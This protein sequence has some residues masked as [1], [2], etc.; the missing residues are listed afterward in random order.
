MALNLVGLPVEYFPNP[1]KARPVFNG[2]I[3]VG[4][5]G[6]DPQEPANQKQV[7]V[8]DTGIT[9][10][11]VA[12]AQPIS[13]GNAGVPVWP[14]S[15]QNPVSVFVDGA[16]SIKV[17]DNND[18]QVYYFEDVTD[19]APLTP[20]TG[21]S[22]VDTIADL[23]SFEPTLDGQQ[24]S[25]KQH[26]TGGIGGGIFIWDSS[27]LTTEVSNDVESAVYVAPSIDLTGASGSW[28]RSERDTLKL[29]MFG[30]IPD[31][32]RTTRIGTDNQ[33]KLNA[34][35]VLCF[36][37]GSKLII[38]GDYGV[39]SE[40]LAQPITRNGLGSG[41][42]GLFAIADNHRIYTWSPS[43]T[44]GVSIMKDFTIQGYA[45]DNTTQGS[46]AN[47]LVEISPMDEAYFIGMTGA[48]GREM[49]FKSRATISIADNCYMHHILRD[50]INFTDAQTRIITNC[51]LEY[52]ADDAIACHSN[53]TNN[54]VNTIITGNQLYNCYGI[55]CLSQRFTIANNRGSVI[56]GYGVFVGQDSPE[57]EQVTYLSSI[58]NNNFENII[59][60]LLVGGGNLGVGIYINPNYTVNANGFYVND[61]DTTAN[62]A[63]D[64]LATIDSYGAGIVKAGTFNIDI[65]GNNLS[66]SW[67]G[68]AN[69]SD[70]GNGD[71]AWTT[72]G[73]QDI[74]LTGTIGKDMSAQAYRFDEVVENVRCHPGSTYGFR[75]GFL[76]NAV[77]NVRNID[78]SFGTM[79][80]IYE[81]GINI[82]L[83]GSISVLTCSNAI[84][85]GGTLDM[86][87]LFEHPDRQLSAGEPT[88]AW[89]N[90][91][92]GATD[93]IGAFFQTVE[94]LIWKDTVCRICKELLL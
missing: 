47:V 28:V 19:G 48:W 73:F 13:T 2:K 16:Y 38:D 65:S 21:V 63:V 5:P 75:I 40:T 51:N 43:I 33:S 22:S 58:S 8:S 94:G 1:L 76:F 17:L 25:L 34:A 86:D 45:Q 39:G 90:P 14:E 83:D 81:K 54:D 79:Q 29:S 66:Q 10:T 15:S 56:F 41:K 32:D 55:K 36:F 71:S 60:L 93:A 27:N 23:R 11:P 52:I 70:Y 80:R 37:L 31:Y 91:T 7:Y 74:A 18:N 72:T 20:E 64:P 4:E 89:T 57:G 87:P 84:F 82:I 6:T 24:V 92:S 12:V 44:S 53:S 68:G 49:G 42:S 78:F 9:Q 88:G 85:S 69:I 77:I 30:A 50:G 46:D 59:N 62:A 3:Y 67:T 26:T 35:E 61:Y